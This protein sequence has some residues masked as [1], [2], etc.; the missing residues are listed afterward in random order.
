MD[1]RPPQPDPLCP[2]WIVEI[3]TLRPDGAVH[4]RQTWAV[5]AWRGQEAI[6]EA[7]ARAAGTRALAHRRGAAL[8]LDAITVTRW[9][10]RDGLRGTG[11]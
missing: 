11:R 9:D 2:T 8:A 6:S 5:Q 3:P 10:W 1:N 7:L 4:G